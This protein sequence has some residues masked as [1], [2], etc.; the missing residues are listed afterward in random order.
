MTIAANLSHWVLLVCVG[1]GKSPVLSEQPWIWSENPIN[2]WKPKWFPKVRV[3]YWKPNVWCSLQELGELLEREG[4]RREG[5]GKGK[6]EREMKRG[7]GKGKRERKWVHVGCLAYGHCHP[8][9]SFM[10][11]QVN[12]WYA[13][14]LSSKNWERVYQNKMAL[15]EL[16]KLQDRI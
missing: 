6:R 7:K 13:A 10:W 11:K 1:P 15:R 16:W 8:H 9:C 14:F 3:C 2:D 4:K 5:K 12:N